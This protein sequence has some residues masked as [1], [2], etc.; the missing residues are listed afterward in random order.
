[1]NLDPRFHLLITDG[2]LGKDNKWYNLSYISQDLFGGKW[3]Y[4]LLTR[5]KKYLPKSERTKKLI[6]KLFKEKRMFI[7]YA[8]Q[9]RKRKVDIVGF[10]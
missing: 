1:M 4:F 3:Q 10:S 9:E 6:D 5:L 8:K 7:T 2:E